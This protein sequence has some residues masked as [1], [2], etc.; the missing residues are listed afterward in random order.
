M[1]I[2]TL[3]NKLLTKTAV[4]ELAILLMELRGD[5]F[6]PP[7][8]ARWR[9][10]L[11]QKDVLFFVLITDKKIVGMVML[12]WHELTGGRT[13][14]VE[15]VVV[16]EGYR[17]KGLGGLLIKKLIQWAARRRFVHLNLTSGP[18]KVAANHLYEKLSFKK[19]DT[20]VYRFVFR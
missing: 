14:T 16:L 13:G 20:N 19:R 15:D 11:A 7:S 3:S 17:G 12:R 9:V 5:S 8:L 2:I 4:R 10:I 6:R 1:K 18:E